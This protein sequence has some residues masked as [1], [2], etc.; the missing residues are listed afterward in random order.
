MLVT[1][2]QLRRRPGQNA[3][4]YQGQMERGKVKTILDTSG[5]TARRAFDSMAMRLHW[6]VE[7]DQ[8]QGAVRMA[9]ST[10]LLVA[11]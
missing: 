8:D 5:R 10:A 4:L 11:S 7:A 2:P 3:V 6:L 1:C 9:A